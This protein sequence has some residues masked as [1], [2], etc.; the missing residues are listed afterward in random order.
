MPVGSWTSVRAVRRDGLSLDAWR[1]SSPRVLAATEDTVPRE[2]AVKQDL[3]TGG[4]LLGHLGG[5]P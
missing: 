3:W 2:T 1:A 5:V 4:L